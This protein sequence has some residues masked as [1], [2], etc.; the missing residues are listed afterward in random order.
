MRINMVIRDMIHSLLGLKELEMTKT[1]VSARFFPCFMIAFLVV[2][3]G[4]K[5]SG[6]NLKGSYGELQLRS[7]TA[8]E[9]SQLGGP[10]WLDASL[11]LTAA[12]H[13]YAG[14]V[15]RTVHWAAVVV[16]AKLVA[17]VLAVEEAADAL[18]K[19]VS[20]PS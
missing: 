16:M 5:D 14:E 12:Y 9:L 13:I 18:K 4:W 10:S 19:R 6:F 1:T 7:A 17:D 11:K 15:L 8:H 3:P 2:G 20:K